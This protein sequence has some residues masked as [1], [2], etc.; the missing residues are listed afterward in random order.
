MAFHYKSAWIEMVATLAAFIPYFV[1]VFRNPLAF[2]GMFIAAVI[3]QVLLL[4]AF[5]V[6]N[7]LATAAIRKRGQTPERDEME[8]QIDLQAGQVSGVALSVIIVIWC[9]SALFGVL[10]QLG[11]GATGA[12]PLSSSAA[13]MIPALTALTAI[14][15][16]FA[17]FVLSNLIYYGSII[18]SYRRLTHGRDS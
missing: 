1:V 6:V 16:L 10:A 9:G 2:P 13:L 15:V 7:A 11:S 14:Q 12:E 4:V 18:L 3:F 17:G 8:R 5:H